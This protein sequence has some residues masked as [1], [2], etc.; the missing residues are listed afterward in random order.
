M[1]LRAGTLLANASIKGVVMNKAIA[2][3]T[4]F[5]PEIAW[6]FRKPPLLFGESGR[7]YEQTATP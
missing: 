4:A 3:V 7:E 1:R 2:T 5:P 6:L